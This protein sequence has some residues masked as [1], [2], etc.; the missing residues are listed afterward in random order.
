MRAA[1][2]LAVLATGCISLDLGS[3]ANA[4]LAGPGRVMNAQY[5]VGGYIRVKDA[6][7]LEPSFQVVRGPLARSVGV[8][9]F[10][11]RAFS[12]SH[13]WKRPG[14]FGV[15]QAGFQGIDYANDQMPV[16]ASM[17]RFGG[18]ISWDVHTETESW[19]YDAWGVIALGVVYTHQTQASIAPADFIGLE[20]SVIGGVYPFNLK[21][22][23]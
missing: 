3:G 18:G 2:V 4:T 1:L 6:A 12:H 21:A 16:D 8:L 11:A 10:G 13:G 17:Y 9:T 14:Y 15:F 7:V 20:L 22:K 5:G 19:L 23:D